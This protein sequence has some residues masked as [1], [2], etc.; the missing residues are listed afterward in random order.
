VNCQ[1]ESSS[2][3]RDLATGVDRLWAPPRL[4]SLAD[5][6]DA[7]FQ[8]PPGDANAGRWKTL[9]YQR[10]LLDAMTDPGIERVTIMKSARVGYTKAFCAFIA[11]HI[12]ADPCPILVVQP[13]IDDATKHSKEDIAPML[14]SLPSL[15]GLVAEAK[16]R[17]PDNTL[18]DKQFRG[19]SLSLVG[20]NSPRGFRR[21]SR[22]VVIFDEVDGYP[23]S[24]GTEGDQIE[25]GVRRTEYYWNRK[26]LAGSTP[27]LAG[28]SR[29]EALFE[30]GDQRR[31][32]LPCP[33]CGV[34]QVLR[35][36][37]LRWPQGKPEQ[38][39]LVCEACGEEIP[40]KM[41]RAMDEAGE[42]RAERPEN[43]TPTHRHA[44]FHIWAGYSYSPNATWGHLALEFVR[45][46][47]GGSF[48]LQTFVNTVLGETFSDRGEAPDYDPLFRRRSSYPIGS[49]P[50]GVLV[51]TAGV[52]VQRDR[53]VY[54]VVG[55]GRGK[56]SWSIDY[57]MLVGETADLTRGPW[58]QLDALLARAFPGVAGGSFSIRRLAIDSGYNTQTVYGWARRYPMSRVIA[59]KGQATGEL[60][61]FPSPLEYVTGKYRRRRAYKVFPVNGSVGKTELYGWLRLAPPDEGEATSPGYCEWPAYGEDY[62]RELT[63]EQLIPIKTRRGFTRYEWSLIP[64]RRNDVLDARI[65]AR[66]AAFVLGVDK[67]TD[68]DYRAIERSLAP[69]T[70]PPP[71]AATS[72][73]EEERATYTAWETPRRQEE[74]RRSSWLPRRPGGWL[75]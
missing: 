43:F 26:I 7:S 36:R 62:F 53:L 49:V 14:A 55:W 15:R 29:I 44:S 47:R 16:M 60:V 1:E 31:R 68:G 12:V 22:R 57:G 58:A 2:V 11:Y 59:I 25:L 27:T 19:G 75:R 20:A 35:L 56:R 69:P 40:H 4:L 66:A 54:E 32:Y 70:A 17:D 61:G 72:S 6:A 39:C 23:A 42:W 45:A 63:A 9:P 18:L 52:D 74:P 46:N 50:P 30:D 28:S 51:L 65:Y 71:T 37:N 24:A 8:L 5:W 48:T 33:R 13:T 3:L 21:T 64:G 34:F 38:A 41:K 10:G 73:P 67:W